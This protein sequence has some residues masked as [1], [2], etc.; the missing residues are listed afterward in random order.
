MNIP[1]WATVLIG[2]AATLGVIS[3]IWWLVQLVITGK[4]NEGALNAQ[5]SALKEENANLK[6]RIKS[7]EQE[8]LTHEG[9]LAEH[10]HLDKLLEKYRHDERSDILIHKETKKAYCKKCLYKDT[11]EVPLE[12]DND[13]W[14]C[15]VCEAYYRNPNYRPPEQP[16]F[17]I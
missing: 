12:V 17:R 13:G 3:F 15:K 7:L 10:T 1:T 5:L 2:L 4:G 6:D 8:N 11:K 14:R 9:K 16:P